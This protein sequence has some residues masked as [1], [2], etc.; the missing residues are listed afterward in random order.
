[1]L[2]AAK[3]SWS[4]SEV[5]RLDRASQC[6][7]WKI[8]NRITKSDVQDGIQP[9]KVNN[10]FVFEDD[11]ILRD[12]TIS[13]RQGFHRYRSAGILLPQGV[14]RMYCDIQ[15]FSMRLLRTRRSV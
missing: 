9:I 13:Y 2:E 6:V 3:V 1:M 4:E 5:S 10:N 7:K 12:E 8:N 14:L 15:I 11:E